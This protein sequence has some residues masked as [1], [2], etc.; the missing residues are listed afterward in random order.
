MEKLRAMLPKNE[1]FSGCKNKCLSLEADE[2]LL[3]FTYQELFGRYTLNK[4]FL[5]AENRRLTYGK[6]PY[7]IRSPLRKTEFKREWE[8]PDCNRSKKILNFR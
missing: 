3:F 4:K 8:K 5:S 7:Q 2:H 1:I 6:F